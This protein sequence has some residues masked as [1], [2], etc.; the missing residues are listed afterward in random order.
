MD[1]IKVLIVEDKLLIAEDIAA[2]LRNHAM[3]I[4]GVC[5]S[6]EEAL[7]LLQ[8]EKPDLILMDIELSGAM[9]GIS[10]AHVIHQH[11]AIPVI[12]LSDFAD[13]KTL[14]RA[15]KTH[16]AN[17]L[18][19]PFNEPELVRAI[20]L[21][22]SNANAPAA[23]KNT[24]LK[25][26]FIFLRA[27]NQVYHKFLLH[28]ILYLKAGPA[29][30]SVITS[31]GEY[32]LSTSMNHVQEQLDEADFIKVHRSYVVNV[33]R[34]TSLD[35]NVIHIGEHEVQMSPEHR[36]ALLLSVKILK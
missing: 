32:V 24:A 26:E 11:Y 31:E 2:R 19:K 13:A 22:F 33:N 14:D 21:A 17:Y 20:D 27:E 36:D 10:T 15:K 8:Q 25:K 16:P 34:I 29:Y 23:K 12:F 3:T 9:D 5:A 18:T 4:A 1:K 30:C 28:D 35:G 7:E 6:G